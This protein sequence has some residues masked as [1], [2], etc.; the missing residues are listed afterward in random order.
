MKFS[1]LNIGLFARCKYAHIY[2]F[3]VEFLQNSKQ[4]LDCGI[5]EKL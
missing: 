4:E 3:V 2:L 5:F 1:L